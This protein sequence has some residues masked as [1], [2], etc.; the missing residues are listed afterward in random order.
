LTA[1]GA[2]DRPGFGDLVGR[3]CE[4]SVG[5]VFC[6]EASAWHGTDATVITCSNSV[7]SSARA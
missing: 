4:G 7:A 3:I 5:A 6:L 2:V 1:S